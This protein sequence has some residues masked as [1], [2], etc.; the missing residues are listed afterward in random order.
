MFRKIKGDNKMKA[1]EIMKVREIPF[2]INEEVYVVVRECDVDK[3]SYTIPCD[4]C[5]TTG[6]ITTT[7]GKTISCPKCWGRGFKNDYDKV[8]GTLT[9]QKFRIKKIEINDSIKNN[10]EIYLSYPKENQMGYYFTDRLY[11]SE[12]FRIFKT[13]EDA[14]KALPEL[15]KKFD[16][17]LKQEETERTSEN[18]PKCEIRV[19]K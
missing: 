11:N 2:E 5:E 3:N 19:E 18:S 7:T 9:I 14:E 10:V 4:L 13:K 17:K 8:R 15:Q 6:K 16:K 1:K 12:F